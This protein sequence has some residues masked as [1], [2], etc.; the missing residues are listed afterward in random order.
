MSDESSDTVWQMA[1]MPAS[2]VEV[3]EK[4]NPAGFRW[5]TP[6]FATYPEAQEQTDPLP[7]E[8]V[9]VNDKRNAGR[10]TFFVPEQSVAYLQMPPART[11]F[12]LRFEHFRSLTLTTPLKPVALPHTDPHAD[13]LSQRSEV[14]FHIALAS[15]GELTGLSI[16]YVERD[17]GLFLFP[18][19][20]TDG[21]V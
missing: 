15:G 8:V 1:T 17:F 12:P 16:G 10:L 2:L 4:S 11:T 18:P 3:V 14:P 19:V 21:S 6:P 5:P 7:C 20:G 13:I 9:G